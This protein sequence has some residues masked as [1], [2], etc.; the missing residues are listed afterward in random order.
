MLQTAMTGA[1]CGGRNSRKVSRILC[2]EA[3][4]RSVMV[5]CLLIYTE[6]LRGQTIRCM[7]R[8]ASCLHSGVSHTEECKS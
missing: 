2:S 8:A 5:D 3:V 6:I 1:S 4:A 7:L